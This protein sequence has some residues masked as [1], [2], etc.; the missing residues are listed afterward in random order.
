MLPNLLRLVILLLLAF[1]GLFML[2]VP[3]SKACPDDGAHNPSSGQFVPESP[4]VQ[5]SL[6]APGDGSLKFLLAEPSKNI[7][8]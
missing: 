7:Y 4:P 5:R 8:K 3:V 1:V 2:C 6:S